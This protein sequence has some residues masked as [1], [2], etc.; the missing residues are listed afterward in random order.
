MSWRRSWPSSRT[1]SPATPSQR[2][3]R[4]RRSSSAYCCRGPWRAVRDRP[5]EGRRTGRSDRLTCLD[6]IFSCLA[7]RR[8]SIPLRRPV[9]RRRAAD[10]TRRSFH[11][12]YGVL[13]PVRPGPAQRLPAAVPVGDRQDR[14]GSRV[15][16]LARDG[17]GR[18]HLH[19]RRPRHGLRPV[20]ADR[21]ST[22]CFARRDG[23]D[24]L[25]GVAEQGLRGHGAVR[26]DPLGAG[27]VRALA[28]QAAVCVGCLRESS[29][30]CWSPTIPADIAYCALGVLAII[31]MGALVSQGRRDY[32]VHAVLVHR[33]RGS[34]VELVL[35]S[36]GL[37]RDCNTAR[38]TNGSTSCRRLP[39]RTCG[40]F[41]GA[42]VRWSA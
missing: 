38:R 41:R 6:G 26:A 17:L 35:T 24:R 27:F 4:Q 19:R 5:T 15:A 30:A 39:A 8:Q 23:P 18:R 29:A 11:P 13:G 12:A 3:P 21:V 42:R 32:L 22:C 16:A 36:R 31:G 25:L 7:D 33:H 10:G 34:R 14:T 9:R 1:L 28:R 40:I 2:R 37:S 20:A